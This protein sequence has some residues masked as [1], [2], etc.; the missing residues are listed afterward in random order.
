MYNS[1]D[2]FLKYVKID[3]QSSDESN[4]SPSTD[5][6]K[7]LAKV[8]LKDLKDL[9]ID[10]A[11]IDEFSQVHAFLNGDKELDI[12]GLNAHV[13]T[14][15]ELSDN[16]V[17]PKII[18]NY[19]GENITLNN[20]YTMSIEEF[21]ILKTLIGK[22][23]VTTDGNTLLGADDKAGL[24]IIMNV[25]KYFTS[26]PEV[27][28]YPISILFTCD[29]E[30]GRG[31]E[32]FDN[33]IFN[34]NYAYTIDG[35]SPYKANYENFNAAHAHIVIKG[36]AIHPGEAKDKMVNASMLAVELIASLNKNEVPEKTSGYEG[37]H[38][39]NAISGTVD[40][41]TIDLII[42]DHDKKLLKKKVKE[43]ENVSKSIAL[44]Y[45]KA[46]FDIQIGYD[47]KNMKEVFRNYAKPIEKIEK[48]YQKLGIPLEF[49]PIRGGTD[50]ATFSFLGCPTPNLGTGSYNHHGRYE[51]LVKEEYDLMIEIVKEILKAEQ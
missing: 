50:G 7:V 27:K 23:L 8:L 25:L 35:D 43:I 38:H 46:S 34:A 9:G 17:K 26:H 3:T 40:E 20:I 29:E 13:D 39:L 18:S 21:P 2:Y 12:I 45:P 10:N 33:K 41:A 47:Y 24:A 5:K 49:V 37:F 6:Q 28:H 22:T 36:V 30:V 14:A 42:R 11:Y 44:K 1:L 16:D 32:H 31:A 19:N 51:F 48:T 15:L 4:S